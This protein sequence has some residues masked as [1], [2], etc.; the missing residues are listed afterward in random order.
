MLAYRLITIVFSP[1]ILTHIVWKSLS[2]KQSRYFWQRLGFGYAKLPKGCPWFHCASV[3]EVN[4][5]L[6]L[7]RTLHAKNERLR[8]IITSNTITG[9]KIVAQQKQPYLH[10]SYLPFDWSFSVRR[11]IRCTRPEA[12]FVVETEIWPN[13]FRLCHDRAIEIHIINARL[14]SKTTSAKA[15]VKA[16]LKSSL[17]KVSSISARSQQDAE[18]YETLGADRQKIKTVG[19]LKFTTALNPGQVSHDQASKQ[20]FSLPRG[21][22][23]LASTHDD[24]ELQF[25]QH[26]KQ[27]GREELLIIVPRHPERGP[28]ITKKLGCKNITVRSKNEAITDQT[29]VY[30]LDTVGELKDYFGNARLVIMGGSF[31]PVG[32]HNILEPASYNRAIITGPFMENFREE[33]VLM[34]DKNAIIQ[35]TS[36]DELQQQM[37]ALLDD[38]DRL[39]AL[40]ENTALLSHDVEQVLADYSELILSRLG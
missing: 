20:P 7:L 8:F 21:Y 10:H 6:P 37:M 22:V 35:V 11:F 24:E 23:V 4:T 17:S 1:L 27:L 31:V 26:W 12:L 19:N 15:W 25:Y 29:E 30:L 13:L 5:L 34:L 28:A 3:G 38:D 39:Q 16:L 9:G 18:A 40:Q 2:N 32:G 36:Y 14:S 33:L